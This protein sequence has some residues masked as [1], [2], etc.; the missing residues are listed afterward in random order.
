MFLIP[1]LYMHRVRHRAKGDR[2][3]KENGKDYDK[4]E[5]TLRAA[6]QSPLPNQGSL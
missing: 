6:R 3:D 1:I 2:N 5:T 4:D